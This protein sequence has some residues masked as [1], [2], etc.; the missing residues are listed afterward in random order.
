MYHLWSALSAYVQ[1]HDIGVLFGVA[2]FHGADPT[3][4]AAPLSLLHHRHLA[5]ET[6]RPIAKGK[7]AVDMN[8]VPEDQLDRR[9]AMVAVPALI[10]AYL[11]LGGVVGQGAFADHAFNTTD[12]C[13]ILDA[14]AMNAR[15]ARLYGVR[16]P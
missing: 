5:P 9:A 14:R 7:N 15:S 10:K 2:S 3:Q 11:R 4:L 16:T 6:L 12:V 13:M 8:I 1:E